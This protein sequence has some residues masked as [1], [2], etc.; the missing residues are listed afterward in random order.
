MI[1]DIDHEG[2][3]LPI[4]VSYGALKCTQE[5]MKATNLEKMFSGEANLTAM[6]TLFWHALRIGHLARKKEMTLTREESMLIWE[7]HFE[8]FSKMVSSGLTSN[9]NSKKKVP[10]PN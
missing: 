8:E 4:K 5:E 6:E 10:A 1:Y 9:K 2:V 3:L 7:D